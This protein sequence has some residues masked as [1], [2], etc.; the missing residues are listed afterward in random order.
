MRGK[1]LLAMPVMAVLLLLGGWVG[2]AEAATLFVGPNESIQAAV[3]AAN[4][5][6]TIFVF[7]AHSEDVLIQKD[8]LRLVGIGATLTP[9]APSPCGDDGFCV[10]G[11]VTFGDDDNPPV[12]NAYVKD[13]HI[14]GFHISGFADTGIIAFGAQNAQFRT[15]QVFDSGGY[16]IAAF[17][18]T[19]TRVQ[20]NVVNGGDE[21]GIYIGD[22][23]NANA[24]VQS[25]AVFDSGF[26]IFLRDSMHG[27]IL[28]NVLQQNC[29]GAL[30][31]ADAPG[32]AGFYTFLGNKIRGNSRA[33]P[34]NEEG[35]A[36][37]GI[38]VA[39]AGAQ[40]NILHGNEITDNVPG[41]DTE[42]SGGLVVFSGDLGTPPN[43]N[44][45]TRNVITGNSPDILW[46]GTGNNTLSPNVCGSSVPPGLC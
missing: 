40:N 3:D 5:Y 20:A 11:D 30:V 37:S 15:N 31:L 46:D 1:R 18:S 45:A 43:G 17:I 38:G 23:P 24:T 6:D 25:N 28:N 7:G 39:I 29:V 36:L 4:P 42:V 33:C 8:G 13:V 22:S 41:G 16:G 12:V 21:A 32:P 2:S 27:S 44:I 19:G 14:S 9:G 35:G 10:F 26:G 34:A